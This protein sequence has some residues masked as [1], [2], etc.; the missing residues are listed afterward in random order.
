MSTF[1]DFLKNKKKFVVQ[2]QGVIGGP[3]VDGA[4]EGLG[5]N[6]KMRGVGKAL[7]QG[8]KDTITGVGKALGQGAKDTAVGVGRA[9]FGQ[10]QDFT[11]NNMAQLGVGEDTREVR[12]KYSELQNALANYYNVIKSSPTLRKSKQGPAIAE[13]IQKVLEEIEDD[14]E[15]TYNMY[16]QSEKRI[17]PLNPIN[18]PNLANPQRGFIRPE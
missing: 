16:Q 2:E 11:R 12:R 6:D 17:R 8:A 5:V 1:T 13:R 15:T 14:L 7:G 18:D 10:N 9:V 3:L 4:L